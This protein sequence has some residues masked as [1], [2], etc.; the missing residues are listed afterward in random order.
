MPWKQ[1]KLIAPPKGNEDFIRVKPCIHG[2]EFLPLSVTSLESGWSP[3]QDD[4]QEYQKIAISLSVGGQSSLFGH[5]SVS[6][7]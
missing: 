6:C 1:S 4:A 3:L 5:I 2:A 7:P